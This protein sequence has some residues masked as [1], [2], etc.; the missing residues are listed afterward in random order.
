MRKSEVVLSDEEI[1]TQMEADWKTSDEIDAALKERQA[2]AEAIQADYDKTSA[3][4]VK[5]LSNA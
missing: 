3:P 5:G 2:N 1:K 4:Y